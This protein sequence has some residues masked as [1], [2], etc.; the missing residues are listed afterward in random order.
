MTLKEWRS[1][2]KNKESEK[3][4]LID[5]YSYLTR[6]IY[7][8]MLSNEDQE[9]LLLI[10]EMKKR[11]KG[12]ANSVDSLTP[13]D[14]A[15]KLFFE[16]DVGKGFNEYTRAMVS[17]MGLSEA[18]EFLRMILG[19]HVY[20]T[21]EVSDE[22]KESE[23]HLIQIKRSKN[24][25]E[26]I[27]EDSGRYT[28]QYLSEISTSGEINFGS[29]LDI[30]AYKMYVVIAKDRLKLGNIRD[31][32][33]SLYQVIVDIYKTNKCNNV[34]DCSICPYV[35][36]TFSADNS[37]KEVFLDIFIEKLPSDI[38]DAD[39]IEMFFPAQSF[40]FLYSLYS[41]KCLS[42]YLGE[43][44][45]I[46]SS[47]PSDKVR[48]IILDLKLRVLII[49]DR[50]KDILH[51]YEENKDA[52]LT[53]TFWHLFA[54]YFYGTTKDFDNAL[55]AIDRL[56]ELTPSNN[57]ILFYKYLI[58]REMKS[59]D[60]A[61]KVL[62]QMSPE[63]NEQREMLRILELNTTEKLAE[64]VRNI[65][66]QSISPTTVTML[67]SMPSLPEDCFITVFTHLVH[68]L[69][70]NDGSIVDVQLLNSMRLVMQ[71]EYFQVIDDKIEDFIALIK[72][73]N[74]MAY[75][76]GFNPTMYS[77]LL[78][79]VT[80]RQ[81][82]INLI[83]T[84]VFSF[85]NKFGLL[86][87]L[88]IVAAKEVLEEY[89]QIL[90]ED[91]ITVYNLY[92]SVATKEIRELR[93]EDKELLMDS[94]TEEI[95]SLFS[96]AFEKG[97]YETAYQLLR[98]QKNEK[99]SHPWYTFLVCAV[100]G[101][102]EEALQAL[103]SMDLGLI[104]DESN[105]N[106]HIL[107]PAQLPFIFKSIDN[108]IPKK[109]PY[110][111]ISL[112]NFISLLKKISDPAIHEII[113]LAI[114]TVCNNLKNNPKKITFESPYSDEYKDLVLKREIMD[115]LAPF[116]TMQSERMHTTA[117]FSLRNRIYKSIQE[118]QEEIEDVIKREERNRILANL[119]HS[120][121]NMLRSVID[122]LQNL[123]NEFPEKKN[124]I[125][126]ALK[127]ANLIREIVNAINLSFK[128][129]LDDLIYDSHN[130]GKDY[131]TL[132]DIITESISYS[133]GN[134]F[135]FRYYPVYAQNYFPSKM[136]KQE[137]ESVKREWDEVYASKELSDFQSFAK[138]NMFDLEIETIDL[139]TYQL[140][141]E[142]SSAI[143]LMILFQE[144]IFNA[145]KYAS[146]IKRE[147]RFIKIA[148]T[149]KSG[150]LALEVSNSFKP[151]VKAKTT[152]VGKLVIENF[153]KVLNCEPEITTDDSVYTI[154]LEF[155]NIWRTHG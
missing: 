144:I 7:S 104:I 87:R 99:A 15:L 76:F 70:N 90:T 17:K 9:A 136:K 148:F 75:F 53:D 13:Y 132:Q 96:L 106:S 103:E 123:K 67:L 134:M 34:T 37:F 120:I 127:G 32:M 88:N 26:T 115:S 101:K 77:Q 66:L 146:F 31:E 100:L 85:R 128:T 83:K 47:N 130:P 41:S 27:I 102:D 119:S 56:I 82:V 48:R 91:Q 145:I 43:F 65:D 28:E 125:E 42:I 111:R 29:K 14:K 109:Y 23:N 20:L 3:N 95:Y 73:N 62:K 142:K 133:I 149:E 36:M 6:Q 154:R 1:D 97:N 11:Y 60:R 117:S 45:R 152:G 139:S 80:D 49:L 121:K 129:S 84:R 25:L 71:N 54:S 30:Y 19:V 69:K 51:L 116:F 92:F 108:L 151:E 33:E 5:Y 58:L 98:L 155:D 35:V 39:I 122:P 22:E 131:L 52:P 107:G 74:S 57:S 68:I 63:N 81:S 10:D 93:R 2:N 150:K 46:L 126:N 64:Y 8:I 79:K 112:I 86:L 61:Q 143:K 44:E 105:T 24:I 138:K 94:G 50:R 18:K 113:D 72:E 118:R 124:I 16:G 4:S 59:I 147:D 12:F 153:A 140:G 40:I 141:N 135:D 21:E 110:D 137:Y 38:S 89:S 55:Y 78:E 114:E